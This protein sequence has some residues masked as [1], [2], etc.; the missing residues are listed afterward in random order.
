M[1]RAGVYPHC[2]RL[3][4]GTLYHKGIMSM[5]LSYFSRV[6]PRLQERIRQ[7]VP[8][9]LPLSNDSLRRCLDAMLSCAPGGEGSS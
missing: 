5:S 3:R 6:L 9:A 2:L 7:D 4:I 1:V 8:S